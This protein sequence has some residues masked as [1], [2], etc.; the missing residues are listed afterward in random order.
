MLLLAAV[1][2]MAWPVVGATV[3]MS[4]SSTSSSG[5]PAGKRGIPDAALQRAF[6]LAVP[7]GAGDA[8]Y[9]VMPGDDSAEGGQDLYLRFRTTPAGLK[10][11]LTSLGKTTGDLGAGDVV[12]EQDDIDSVG[13]RW[14]IATEGHLAGLYA[15]IPEQG[16]RAGAARVTVDESEV[17]APLVY[18]HMTV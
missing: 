8:S 2:L 6:R 11:F 18:A 10:E 14:K 16:D 15:D 13:L 1:A 5:A 7:A 12:L 9:L 17:A 3:R 4:P